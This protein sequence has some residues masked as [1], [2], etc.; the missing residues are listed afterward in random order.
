MPSAQISYFHKHAIRMTSVTSS[1]NLRAH[2]TLY[3]LML[4]AC[5]YCH[6]CQDKLQNRVER[7]LE[8]MRMCGNKMQSEEE[9]KPSA[10]FN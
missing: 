7:R 2:K 10:M 1:K 5:P 8:Q 4:N 3:V 9:L 6:A